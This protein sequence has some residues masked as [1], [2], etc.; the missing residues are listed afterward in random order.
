MAHAA[1]RE[2]AG[3]GVEIEAG[4]VGRAAPLGMHEGDEARHVAPGRRSGVEVRGD[5]AGDLPRTQARRHDQ[6]DLLGCDAAGGDHRIEGQ[7][8]GRRGPHRQRAAFGHGAAADLLQ[9]FPSRAR[10]VAPD[11]DLGVP[12]ALPLAALPGGDGERKLE[13]L[14]P[15]RVH[16]HAVVVAPCIHVHLVCQQLEA[17]G[18]GHELERRHEGEVGDRPV[19]GDEQ[20]EGGAGRHLACDAL[21]VVA[22]AVH[23]IEAARAHGLAIVDDMVEPDLR[24]LL[25]R[26][27]ERL[28]RDVVEAAK[29]V[30]SRGVPFRRGPVV[31]RVA[32]EAL[33]LLQEGPCRGGIAHVLQH[34]G[35]GADQLVGLGQVGGAAVADDFLR[36][37]AGERVAGDA[38]ERVRAA[39][40]QREAERPRRLR[41]AAGGG[42]RGQPAFDERGCARDL[43]L[44]AAL[45]AEEPV[46]HMV[47]RVAAALHEAPQ[48]VVA[49]GAGAVVGRKH[50]AHIGVH[51]EPRQHPEHLVQIVGP[52]G[53][54]A[55]GM[56]HRDHSVDARRRLG[57]GPVRDRAHEAVGARRGGQHRHYVAGA[58]AAPA[59]AA[60]AVEGGAGVGLGDLDAGG[61]A[62]VVQPVGLDGVREVGGLGQHE[63][64]VAFRQCAQYPLVADILAGLK[65]AGRD[66]EGK[67]PRGEARALRDGDA[68][69]AV[70][71]EDGVGEAELARPV[72]DDGAG[73]EAPRRDRDIVSRRRHAGHPVEL[74]TIVHC[75]FPGRLPWAS[76]LARWGA[77]GTA[78]FNIGKRRQAV[79][80]GQRRRAMATGHAYARRPSDIRSMRCA[81][82]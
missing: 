27:A 37:P 11:R 4:P 55:F 41:R 17:A 35:L 39:A 15:Q 18:G 44:V 76:F 28:Q 6:G 33:D 14:R 80:S 71:F 21:Q 23:E 81:C 36:H 9:P 70:P 24:G 22:G 65:G 26:R 42:D 53:A 7:C 1:M 16:R 30:P 34:V 29:V 59:G 60:E 31:R 61:E 78:A 46:R 68:D 73:L 58:D 40:L 54:A 74:E 25:A 47:E 10:P 69:E 2:V 79:V 3:E 77:C 51:H 67:A 63:V 66:A 72:R 64:D 52:P 50:G 38:G 56:G 19:P 8:E 32:F 13:G 57:R 82:A 62:G 48:V 5:E 43:R 20:D 49:V 45:D 75:T 12:R